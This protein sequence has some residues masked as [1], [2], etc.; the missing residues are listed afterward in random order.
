M[1]SLQTDI[2]II[3]GGPGGYG[4]A[5]LAAR[6]GSSV[7]LIERNK[8]GGTCLNEGC[9]PTKALLK[10]AE[11]FSISKKAGQYG[12]EGNLSV[13]NYP[14]AVQF[15][16]QVVNR[17]QGG[18]A[19]LVK[20]AHTNLLQGVAQ[21]VNPHLVEVRMDQDTVQIETQNIIIATGSSEIEIPGFRFDGV[22]ILN[23]SHMLASKELPKQLAI[24]GGG[25]IGCEFASIFNRMGVEVT[26]IELTP[27]VIPT[28]D[29]ELS[30]AL[31]KSLQQSGV[32][33]LTNCRAK[34]A[35][36]QGASDVVVKVLNNEGE[37]SDI[38]CSQILVCVG[39][40]AV[41]DGSGILEQGV[42]T[43][44]GSILTNSRMQT[45]VPGIYAVGDVTAS[46]QLAHVAY[47]EARVAV[48]NILGQDEEMDYSAV[49]HCIYTSPEVASVG[50][51][52]KNAR[53][54]FTDVKVTRLPFSGNGKA[55]IEGQTDGFIKLITQNGTNRV[56]GAGII[57]PKATELIAE[58]VLAVQQKT[59]VL[60]LARTIHAHPTLSEAS[61]E[62]S[63]AAVGWNLHSM[64]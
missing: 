29:E 12:V 25:V 38:P 43:N 63:L 15:K 22:N 45:S 40:K 37:L 10:C 30:L 47:H 55:L 41:L 19:Y 16:E 39:R 56:L 36:V 1:A 50:M 5:L 48:L 58:F 35:V 53:E 20:S 24:I 28:E 42:E 34:E 21:I 8:L 9:I 32:R 46:E 23:S 64:H 26:I 62:I 51:T 33:I 27:R 59:T 14:K 17:L 31:Q 4:A 11:V 18:V 54:Q 49:P 6:M 2:T 60:D 44:R 13:M 57:G 7:T 61:G 3:G 52:E